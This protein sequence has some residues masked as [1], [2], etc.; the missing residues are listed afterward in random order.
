MNEQVDLNSVL[1]GVINVWAEMR[2]TE[3]RERGMTTEERDTEIGI[4]QTHDLVSHDDISDIRRWLVSGMNGADFH[5]VQAFLEIAKIFG[6]AFDGSRQAST[7]Q[8]KE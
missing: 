8:N 3:L 6:K 4:F 7:T 2:E 1:V 5:K